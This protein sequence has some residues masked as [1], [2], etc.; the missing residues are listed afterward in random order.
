MFGGKTRLGNLGG[1]PYVMPMRQLKWSRA[2]AQNTKMI[3]AKSA[4][5]DE[6]YTQSEDIENELRHYKEHFSGKVVLCNC[7]DPAQSNF[8][9]YFRKK[10]K[11]LGLKKLVATHFDYDERKPT[12]KL[13]YSGNG[14]EVKTPL[15]GNGDFRSAECIDLLQEADIVVT[16][17]PF[18]LFRAYI[19]QL[20][21]HD[22]KFLIIGN[23]NALA[24]K[25]I[26]PFVIGGKIWL[27]YGMRMSFRLHK[28]YVYDAKVGRQEKDGSN[29]VEIRD[30][31]WFTNLSHDRKNEELPLYQKYDPQLYQKY[32]NYDAID[33][34]KVKDIPKDYD[35]KIGVPLSFLLKHNPNQFELI[36]FDE[37]LI[38]N[39]F[40]V[41]G[42]RKYARLVIKRKKGEA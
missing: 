40:Y 4:K 19:A 11:R 26:R 18:S 17:P 16:N 8:W 30:S 27:G 39:R 28:D 35:G 25:E 20:M 7:D 10:F 5:K 9:D 3:Q 42:K 36:G 29:Y 34:G 37:S 31:V 24:Y 2:M 14:K 12:Y 41:G 23:M 13:E 38:G 6:F 21:E 33:V 1:K 15:R 22:K 32:D